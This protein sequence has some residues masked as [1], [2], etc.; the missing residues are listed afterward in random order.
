M[1][2]LMLTPEEVG[3]ALGVGR[4]TVYDLLRLKK[5]PSVRIGRSRRVRVEDLRDYVNRLMEAPVPQ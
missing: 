4:S 5:L 2:K 1:E 3:D